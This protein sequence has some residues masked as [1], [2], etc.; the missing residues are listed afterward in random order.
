[1]GKEPASKGASK[2]VLVVGQYESLLIAGSSVKAVEKVVARLTSGS[3]PALADEAAFEANRLTMFREA[4]LFAWFNAK[5]FFEI[6]ARM[7]EEKPDPQAPSP[8]PAFS[9]SKLVSASGLTSLKTVAFDLRDSNEGI[10]YEVFIGAPEAG[11]RGLFKILAM[12]TKDS[13]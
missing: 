10:M 9:L 12:E 13:N 5:A 11:R 6:L 3:V 7:P 8:L 1:L 2:S 4:P